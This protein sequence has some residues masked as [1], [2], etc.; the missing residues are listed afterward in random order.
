MLS[1]I[2]CPNGNGWKK[3]RFF[4]FTRLKTRTKPLRITHGTEKKTYTSWWKFTEAY[5]AAIAKGNAWVGWF[6]CCT[7][8]WRVLNVLNYKYPFVRLELSLFLFQCKEVLACGSFID[9]HSDSATSDGMTC[10]ILF[11]FFKWE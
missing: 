9:W 2:L 10:M 3:L 8:I 4:A 5:R 11:F 7:D 6:T 1:V